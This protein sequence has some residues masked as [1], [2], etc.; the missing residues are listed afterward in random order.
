MSLQP[1]VNAKTDVR[2]KYSGFRKRIMEKVFIPQETQDRPFDITLVVADGKE[3]KVHRRVL[4]EASPFFEKVLN[5][6]MKESDEGVIHLEMLTELGMRDILE[7]I[8][9]GNIQISSE[10]HAQDLIAMADYLV[11]PY[12]KTVSRRFFFQRLK[13]NGSISNWPRTSLQPPVLACM[14]SV[15][16]RGTKIAIVQVARR[17]VP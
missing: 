15:Q 2:S 16:T 8:Y 6:D 14:T 12:L 9:T 10:D 1:A 17:L 7:F 4:S 3:F 11:L 5:S 13:L